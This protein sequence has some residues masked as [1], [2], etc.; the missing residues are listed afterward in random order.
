MIK[1]VF[2]E[3]DS[4]EIGIEVKGHADSAPKGQDLICCAVSTIVQTAL[5]GCESHVKGCRSFKNEGYMKFVSPSTLE[6]RAILRTAMVGLV[7]LAE[8]YPESFEE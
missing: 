8:Q 5:L 1:F 3:T 2:L 7:A 6:T 4:G